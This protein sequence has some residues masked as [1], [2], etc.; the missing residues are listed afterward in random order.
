MSMLGKADDLIAQVPPDTRLRAGL[1]LL[2]DFFEGRSHELARRVAGLKVG[3]SDR[4]PVDG[5]NMFILIQCYEARLRAKGRFEAHQ[6]YTD[7]Q[8][9]SAGHEWI[10]VCDVQ[11][12]RGLPEFDAN[13]NI[14]FPLADQVRSCLRLSPGDVA[15]LF[16]RDA[17]APCLRVEGDSQ[18]VRKVAVKVRDALLPIGPESRNGSQACR[19]LIT[20]SSSSL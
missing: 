13:G 4:I 18:L 8:S 10:E 16:P 12:Q 14:Y 15:V 19:E 5:D 1:R 3:E 7:L 17:H 11:A 9:L 6:R 20:C 2:Q